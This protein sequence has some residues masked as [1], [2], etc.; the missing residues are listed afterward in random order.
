M[1]FWFMHHLWGLKTVAVFDIWSFEHVASGIS[2]G[3]AVRRHTKWELKRLFPS[4]AHTYHSLH[5][6][7]SGV[8]FIGYFWE[9]IEHYLETGLAGARVEYWFQGVEYWPNRVI[10]DP[11]LLILG[12]LIAKRYP[13]LVV[14]ARIFSLTWLIVHIFAFPDSMYLQ[15]LLNI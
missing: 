14:P 1:L 4:L 12:Y 15:R 5:F 13:K 11:A 2:I 6:D 3:T 9:T 8:L 10:A 7:L